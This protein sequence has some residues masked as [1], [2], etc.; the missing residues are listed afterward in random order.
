MRAAACAAHCAHADSQAVG[1]LE[2][3]GAG[4]VLNSFGTL[5]NKNL[6]F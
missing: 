2:E 6:L 5:N 4:A 3:A 1:D